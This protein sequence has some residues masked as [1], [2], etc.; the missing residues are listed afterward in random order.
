MTPYTKVYSTLRSLI[1]FILPLLVTCLFYILIYR[2]SRNHGPK[3]G[4]NGGLSSAK[5]P[6]IDEKKVYLKSIRAAKTTSMF[7]VAIF[8][9]WQ[10]FSYFNTVAN[11]V[12][13]TPYPYEL[14]KMLLMLCYLN[15]APNPFLFAFRNKHFKSVFS[16]LRTSLKLVWLSRLDWCYIGVIS[17]FSQND[18]FQQRSK[19][20]CS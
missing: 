15:S 12:G 3:F 14:S 17:M 20:M 4:N 2:I 19:S 16:K 1:N 18:M 6:T 10:P 5:Q 11:W 9:C 7:I 8:F 13:L